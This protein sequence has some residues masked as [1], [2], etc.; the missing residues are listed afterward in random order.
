MRIV[1]IALSWISSPHGVFVVKF[2]CVSAIVC[3]VR[4]R[5]G[6]WLL[7]GVEVVS[8]VVWVRCVLG[9]VFWSK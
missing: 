7:F 3:C 1:S 6:G 4:I 2:S 5:C 8:N 9:L